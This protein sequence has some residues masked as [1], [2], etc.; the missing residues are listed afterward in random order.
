[1][2]DF[3]FLFGCLT[4]CY[5]CLFILH[6]KLENIFK[7]VTMVHDL[8]M[9]ELTMAIHAL[10]KQNNIESDLPMNGCFIDMI[11]SKMTITIRDKK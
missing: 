3:Y 2:N 1:M 10:N 7:K 6:I 9:T 11:E 8:R 4:A 5:V